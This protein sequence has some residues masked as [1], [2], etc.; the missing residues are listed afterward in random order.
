MPDA[1]RAAVAILLRPG[2]RDLDI[3]LIERSRADRDPWSG[4]MA[5]PGGRRQGDENDVDTAIREAHEEVGVHLNID[6]VFLGRLDDVRPAR[7]GPPIAV[8]AFVFAVPGNTTLAPNHG[9][10]AAA[11][12]IPL[13]H[14][15]DPAVAAKHL[16]VMPEGRQ[17]RFPAIMYDGRV[18][19]GLTYRMLMQ[20]LEIV[21]SVQQEDN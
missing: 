6:G 7:G 15:A 19:W 10:V 4:H 3:L 16:H 17:R 1:L 9:E 21:R 8:A 5:F 18:I 11:F 12:W 13:R 2:D 20:F 14:L